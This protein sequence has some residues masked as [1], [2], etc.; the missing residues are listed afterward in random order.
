[1][2]FIMIILTIIQETIV[3]ALSMAPIILPVAGLILRSP[4]QTL[5]IQRLCQLMADD[6]IQWLIGSKHRRIRRYPN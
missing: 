5:E 3:V 1:M 6:V 2:T 4:S